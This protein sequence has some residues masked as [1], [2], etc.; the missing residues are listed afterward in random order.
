V[1]C[2]GGGGD[3]EEL[4]RNEIEGLCKVNEAMTEV[5]LFFNHVKDFAV[6]EEAVREDAVEPPRD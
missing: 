1:Q 2:E 4:L 6:V 5:A 3:D